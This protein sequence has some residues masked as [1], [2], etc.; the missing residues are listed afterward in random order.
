MTKR[1]VIRGR[2]TPQ[3]L[4]ETYEAI[5]WLWEDAWADRS[6]QRSCRWWYIQTLA[7]VIN[8]LLKQVIVN[9]EPL[10]PAENIVSRLCTGTVHWSWVE[11]YMEWE[12][13]LESHGNGNSFGLLMGMGKTSWEWEWHICKWSPVLHSNMQWQMN[14]EHNLLT[15][16]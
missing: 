8:M 10:N 2:M 6:C 4:V 13:P 3:K 16:D 12:F 1:F 9:L 5:S 7:E 14:N 15:V 11:V